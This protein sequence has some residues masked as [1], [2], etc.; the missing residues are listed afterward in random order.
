ML[1]AAIFPWNDR[2]GRFSPLKAAVLVACALP[3][4]ILGAMALA[5]MLG[6]KPLTY[7]IH[8]TGDWAVR[9][10]LISLLVTP[11][12]TIASWPQL[13]A[14]RRMLGLTA[15]AY[16]LAHL[17]LYV[18]EQRYDM[19]KVASE[20]VLRFYLTIGFVALIGLVSLGVTSTDGMIRR[21]GSA[22]W[23][24]LHAA[25]YAITVL[26]LTHFFIQSKLDVTQAVLMSG[27]FIW[28]MAFRAL[29]KR[30]I[31]VTALSL[32]GIA[33]VAAVLTALLEAA[34]YAGMTGVAASRVL[35]ANLDFSFTIRPA[36][37]VLAAGMALAMLHALRGA[38][39]RRRGPRATVQRGNEPLAQEAASR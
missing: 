33:A 21:L 35:E 19:F 6:S 28:L 17:A 10:L 38:K 23:N 8:D 39:A 12:R 14:V 1:N 34:W 37:W 22:R 2:A 32:T 13:I 20:I 25:V 7:A 31:G 24:R 16:V 4:A 5:G 11:L 30:G 36:W 26:A 29:R 15:L 18:V 3:M 9:I 27:F